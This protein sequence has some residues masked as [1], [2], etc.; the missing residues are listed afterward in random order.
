M[1]LKTYSI[2]C[3]WQCSGSIEVK[4]ENLEDAVGWSRERSIIPIGLYIEDSFEIDEEG[5]QLAYPNE[6]FLKPHK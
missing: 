5:I 1:I 4:A 2:P 3:T 6:V